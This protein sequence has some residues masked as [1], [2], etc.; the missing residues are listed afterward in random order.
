MENQVSSRR[1]GLCS[2]LQ[3]FKMRMHI[4]HYKIKTVITVCL[5]SDVGSYAL[6]LANV[7]QG[8]RVTV[9]TSTALLGWG[10]PVSNNENGCPCIAH[11]KEESQ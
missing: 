11:Q 10:S 3:S 9:K 1:C 4:K 7:F 5:K 6:S 8:V 2:L